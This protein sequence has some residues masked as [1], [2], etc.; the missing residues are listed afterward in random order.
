MTTV[1][2]RY[3]INAK[4]RLPDFESVITTLISQKNIAINK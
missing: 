4:K 2:Q 3:E 1:I